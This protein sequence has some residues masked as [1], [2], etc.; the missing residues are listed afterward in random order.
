MMNQG[1][2]ITDPI[3]NLV[4]HVKYLEK[5]L[6]GSKTGYDIEYTYVEKKT[7]DINY[8]VSIAE[9]PENYSKNR[10]SNV[11]P[12]DDTRVVLKSIPGV[13]GSDFINANFI[14]AADGTSSGYITTQGPLDFTINDFWRMNLENNTTVVVMLT[15]DTDN[16][17]CKCSKYWAD[18]FDP[19]ASVYFENITV[20]LLNYIDTDIEDLIIRKLL[21][22]AYQKNDVISKEIIQFQYIGWPDQGL[23]PS[24]HVF[25]RLVETVDEYAKG[26]LIC[27]HCSAGIG[28]TGTFCAIHI[29][30]N[31]I[32]NHF[33]LQSKPPY[34]NIVNTI[35]HLR[36]QRPG[37]V[38]TKDQ[39]IFCYKAILEEYIKIWKE[40]LLKNPE[41]KHCSN[42]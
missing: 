7:Q 3:V 15:K 42:K 31:I 34:L 33:R 26:G 2:V 17:R 30:L 18:S 28:R 41:I 35:L 13:P 36:K 4:K 12:P 23:P 37:M 5:N 29:N 1:R 14:K 27:V 40:T 22:T 9:L 16:G 6:H 25:T 39:F 8:T 19:H 38:Q 32:R 20:K 10:Y 24:T 11:K 21:V